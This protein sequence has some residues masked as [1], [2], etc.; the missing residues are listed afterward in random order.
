M[1]LDTDR[2]LLS[3]MLMAGIALLVLVGL[4]SFLLLGRADVGS[5]DPARAPD[6]VIDRPVA[7]NPELAD[8]SEYATIIERPMFFADRRL[9]V[10]ELA[11][12]DAAEGEAEPEPVAEVEI[13]EL[14]ATVAGIII[15][16]ELKLAMITDN[17]SNE[18]LVLREGM[19][20][21]GEKSAWTISEIR[22]RG[23]QFE[24][25][26]GRT[27]N[28][29]L[30]VETSAL[31]TG[32][33]PRRQAAANT[34]QQQ[35][36]DAPAEQAGGEDAEAQARARAEEIRRRVAERRAQLRAEAERRAQEQDG[37]R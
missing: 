19:A 9:P 26:G 29:E 35:D 20:M 30:E 16:P 33:P 10:I 24:T 31:K 5:I 21:A 4:A 8:L 14:G 22:A 12:G 1:K 11:D 28:L 32:A 25:E 2:N 17:S 27:E 7:Q 34:S 13:P 37:G 23:V 18:T 15:T 6:S 3:V 36:Q